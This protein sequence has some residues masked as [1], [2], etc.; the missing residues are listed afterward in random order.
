MIGGIRDGDSCYREM[1]ATPPFPSRA[2]SRKSCFIS[3]IMFDYYDQYY[4]SAYHYRRVHV[5]AVPKSWTIAAGCGDAAVDAA[6]RLRSAARA[7]ARAAR[8]S[9][10]VS[11]AAIH[12]SELNYQQASGA[13]I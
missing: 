7:S 4:Y 12:V 5:S 1:V 13:Y 6:A 3:I 11:Q 8:V 9:L 10:V 2:P